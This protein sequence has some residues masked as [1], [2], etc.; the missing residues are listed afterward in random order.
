MSTLSLVFTAAYE[1]YLPNFV[2]RKL[3]VEANTKLSITES[4]AEIIA[5]GLAGLL[6]QLITAPL[7]VLLDAF[8]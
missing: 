3:L 2:G 1:S 8:T 5:P 4:F 7:A 6:V